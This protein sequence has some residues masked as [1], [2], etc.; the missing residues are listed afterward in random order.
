[1]AAGDPGR[2][3]PCELCGGG[4]FETIAVEDRT[5]DPLETVM[6]RHCGLVCHARLPTAAELARFYEHDYRVAYHGE[7]VPSVRRVVRAWKNGRRIV[8]R[9]A[10]LLE[11]G[12]RVLEIGAGVG[13]T[14]KQFEQ[15]GFD[16][17]GVEP[18]RGFQA[19]SSEMLRARVRHGGIED[20]ARMGIIDAVLLVHVIEH[21]GSPREALD[22]IHAM[23]RP[24]GL[25][26]VECPNLAAPFA[27]RARLFHRAHTFN[28]TPSSLVMLAGRCGFEPVAG[29]LPGLGPN[30]EMAFHK[31]RSRALVVDRGNVAS[32]RAALQRAGSPWYHAR[33]SYVASR[34]AKLCGYA[35]EHLVGRRR[36]AAIL[37][38]C[39]AEPPAA[40]QPR[41]A[42]A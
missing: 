27:T 17:A 24:G 32:T 11:R 41:R 12:A 20:V 14:V 31:V 37:R 21:F 13:C 25:L 8:E 40:R 36:L 4:D 39:A 1:M 6:C 7:E 19:Y 2:S 42:A 22:R 10:P 26:Y 5:G 29:F 9:V 15:A 38:S 16:A 30:L 35:A 18:N 34:V 33:P 28:F 23:L 3:E